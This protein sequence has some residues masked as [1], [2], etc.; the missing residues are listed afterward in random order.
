MLIFLFSLIVINFLQDSI[1]ISILKSVFDTVLKKPIAIH[2]NYNDSVKLDAFLKYDEYGNLKE[3]DY[4]L[5]VLKVNDVYS[6]IFGFL[7]L[8]I[9]KIDEKIKFINGVL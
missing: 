5:I 3:G 7:N 1:S 2:S 6:K 8:P 4:N 9:S